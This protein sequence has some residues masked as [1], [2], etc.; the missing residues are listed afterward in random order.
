VKR[1]R[2]VLFLPHQVEGTAFISERAASALFDEQGL[3]KT[4]QLIDSV[5]RD[6]QRGII[7]GAVVVCPNTLKSTWAA[8]VERHSELP[9][10]VFGAGK[11]ARRVAFSSLK[12]IFYIINYE[13]VVREVSSL[14]A[15]LRFKRMAFVLDE[16]H[17]IKNPDAK[18]SQAL[19]QLNKEASK[20]V[21]MT[22]TP[23]ANRPEDLWSQV[24]FLDDGATFG[25]SFEDFRE[26]YRTASGGYVG[27]EDFRQRVASISLRRTKEEALTL[28][29]K[30]V[31]YLSVRLKGRQG[32]MYERMRRDLYLW[33]KSLSGQEVLAQAE[34]I[35]VRLL[36]LAQLAS[37]PR[38]LDASYAE[39]PA[40]IAAL[41]LKVRQVLDS[42]PERKVILWT[43]FVANIAML[44]ERYARFRPVTFH[45]DMAGEERDRSVS[46]FTSDASVRMFIGNPAA[47]RE[48]LTLTSANVAIYLDRTFNLVDYLQSQDR[49]HRLTQD[50]PCEIVLLLAEDTVDEFIDFSLAQKHRLARFAQRDVDVISKGDLALRK[51]DILRALLGARVS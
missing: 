23:I 13:A 41:D 31:T 5:A 40:K 35:L 36:R 38:L 29:S 17:R 11:R 43:S 18:V 7:A 46:A 6:V 2:R 51:P 34:N 1:E 24:F 21:I 12:A 32:E 45:G 15:L 4:K 22:G 30:K 33:V 47:G 26:R 10:A 50:L 9:Y 3:G 28:P 42:T 20:R 44:G 16:S 14:R 49:I 19:H 39:T 25:S 48:G 27:L 37:N 8:E